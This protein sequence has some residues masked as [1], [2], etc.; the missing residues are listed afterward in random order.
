M[1]WTAASP[2]PVSRPNNCMQWSP[3]AAAP[4][5][6]SSANDW[7]N[8]TARP[9][10]R[11]SNRCTRWR[12]GRPWRPITPRDRCPPRRPRHRRVSPAPP[13][14]W[15]QPRRA[16]RECPHRFPRRAHPGRAHPPRLLRV[17]PDKDG[18]RR[19]QG[20]S[21]LKAWPHPPRSNSRQTAPGRHQGRCG[22]PSSFCSLS[23]L[24][25]DHSRWYGAVAPMAVT[26]PPR[27]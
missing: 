19:R 12:A 23:W 27:W 17:S 1:R 11:T 8:G 26:A 10:R 20:S 5:S 21:P 4:E 24:V 6:P 18:R 13:P 22:L 9:Y 2:W 15:S 25:P 14:R 3:W 16:Q 7:R